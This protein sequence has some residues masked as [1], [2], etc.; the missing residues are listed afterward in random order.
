MTQEQKEEA[1]WHIA[2]ELRELQ[3]LEAGQWP[4]WA[5]HAERTNPPA[6]E[7]RRRYADWCLK[8]VLVALLP[9]LPK[10]LRV[11]V[12]ACC[13]LREHIWSVEYMNTYFAQKEA[14]SECLP[15]SNSL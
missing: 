1:Q 7:Q 3:Q 14:S 12:Q 2:C 5:K 15:A 9:T 4:E 6:L 13:G 11:S 8:A 10:A